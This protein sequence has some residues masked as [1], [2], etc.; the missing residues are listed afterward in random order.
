MSARTSP[1][2]QGHN[3][4][5]SEKDLQEYI[6]HNYRRVS[7]EDRF[8]SAIGIGAL[9]ALGRS[10]DLFGKLPYATHVA[11]GGVARGT[12]L[13]VPFVRNIE[14]GGYI[15]VSDYK[16][17]PT[18]VTES[19]MARLALGNLGVWAPHQKEYALNNPHWRGT[20]Q[21]AGQLAKGHVHQQDIRLLEP[22]ST[23][24]LIVEHGPES[25]ADTEEEYLELI[26]PL[27]D[28]VE[29]GGILAKAYVVESGKYDV[30]GIEQPAYPV[31][32]DYVTDMLHD[33]KFDILVNAATDPSHTIRVE[34]DTH[35]YGGLGIAI[36]TK[37][38]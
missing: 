24:F 18:R 27:C 29:P 16:E 26:H 38:R 3:W 32:P 7:R 4:N 33:N 37:R 19:T 30:G 36:A 31:T 13:A 28:A 1:E 21:Q 2:H 10:R 5:W 14:E 20:F 34:G 17:T 8:I 25:A 12:A 22:N 35:S 6:N 9:A 23:P 15:D 11:A